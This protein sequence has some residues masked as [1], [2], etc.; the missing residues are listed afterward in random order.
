MRFPSTLSRAAFFVLYATAC[1]A[2]E[3]LHVI[4]AN[5]V[6]DSPESSQQLVVT[7]VDGQGRSLDLTH[8]AQ[9]LTA[10]TKVAIATKGGRI[11]PRGEGKTEISIQFG[12]QT[13]PVA[14]E[15]RG[16]RS[17]A[18]VS[19]HHQ[20]IPILSKAGC[21]SGSCHGKAEG[22]NGFKLSVFG[23][24]PLADHKALVKESRG[25]RISIAA[26]ETSLMLRKATA[27][28]PHGGGRKIEQ[29]SLWHRRLLRW[30]S[31]GAQLDDDSENRV[32]SIEVEPTQLS[33]LSESTVQLQV[34]A[35]DEH[36]VRRCVT[37]ES[38]Y[39][40]NAEAIATVDDHGI[41]TSSYIPGE[42]AI[43][44]RYMDHVA[45]CRVTLPQPSGPLARPAENNFID[46]LVWDK[47]E[48]LGIAS[49]PLT[50]DSKFMRRAYLDTI[51][52]LPTVDEA[53][54][55]LTDTAPDKRTALI[56]NLLQRDEYADYWA[57]R[58]ADVLRA[59]QKIIKPQGTVAFVRWLRRQIANNTPYDQF[60]REILAARGNTLSESPAA[61]FQVHKDPEEL[62]RAVS[63]LFLGVRIECA[64][65]HHH[66][67]ERWGQADYYSFA[68]FFTGV[69]RTGAPYGGQKIFPQAG[70]DLKHPRTDE[71]AV[72]SGLG[73]EPADLSAVTERRVALADWMTSPDNPF[74]ARMIANRLWAHYF[75]RG[76]VEPI[77]DMRATNPATNEPLLEA[78]ADHLIQQEF[79]IKAF[80]RTLLSSRVYQLSSQSNE[81]NTNDVQNFSHATWKALPA[82]ILLDAICQ[83]TDVPEE[84]NG[85]PSG[86][87]AIQVWDNRM[88]SYFF[89]IFGRPQRLT[90]C[91]CERG[92]EPSI[93]QALHL[94]NSPES[95]RKIRHREGRAAQL[96]ASDLSP[97]KIIE[98]LYLATLSRFPT[99]DETAL[100]RQAFEES[101]A[102]HRAATEDVLWTLLNTREFVY[103]H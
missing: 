31:E 86:Y 84:F 98:T 103:N 76:L 63:Q 3:S 45:V 74:F 8:R 32:Q 65:C 27:Q 102:N 57:M 23:F 77:D 15:V 10:D 49:S 1:Q 4:P 11:L 35:T 70:E 72:A 79:D 14:I 99:D 83:A 29:N 21:N 2:I 44:V 96:A 7:G 18:P 59:D 92:N 85:W 90:V 78:L 88:P 26:P 97:E 12:D 93:A 68:S 25:R 56:E 28:L 71:V 80:T 81:S 95:V 17:P 73:A 22:K 61:F 91:E 100:M 53:R 9:Y 75:G 82:E 50:S 46:G 19:F 40:S 38:E 51:G 20:V 6:L 69:G 55:F 94:M 5:C 58:W 42:A 39:Q 43:L 101:A 33:M 67:F 24:D 36:G 34:T 16:I 87:R 13:V 60:A 64:Q 52:T 89:R 62:G 30:I 41:I 54:A 66:P 47:L 48:Q 37:V